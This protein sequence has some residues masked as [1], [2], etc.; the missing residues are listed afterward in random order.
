MIGDA[1]AFLDPVYSSGLFL[2]LASAELAAASIHEALMENDFSARKLGTFTAPLQQGVEVIK[3]LIFAFYDPKFS[4]G[5]F[6]KMYPEH[7]RALIDCLVGDVIYKDMSSFLQAL[8]EMSP[9]M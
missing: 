9:M 6:V 3:R 2:A 5:D 7:R 8:D 1:A 4:F